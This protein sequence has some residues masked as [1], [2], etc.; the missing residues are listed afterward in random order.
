MILQESHL[1]QL[2]GNRTKRL[3]IKRSVKILIDLDENTR[4]LKEMQKKLESLGDSL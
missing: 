4:A 1:L 3:F 2:S